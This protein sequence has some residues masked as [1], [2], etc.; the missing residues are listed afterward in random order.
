MGYRIT[1]LG[2]LPIEEDVNL[3]I[4]IVKLGFNTELAKLI[5]DNFEVLARRI[6]PHQSAIVD[7]LNDDWPNQ[8][9]SVFFGADW[10]T[11]KQYCPLMLITNAHPKDVDDDSLRLVVPLEEVH[12][13][14]GTY[15]RFF[16]E[17]SEFAENRNT[18]F[19]DKFEDQTNIVGTINEIIDIKPNVFG[20]GINI[21]KIIEKL[22]Q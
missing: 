4:F 3:Y 9:L 11:I 15:D 22:T 21:N 1:T 17:L 12:K 8:V 16:A 19:L 18:E 10:K 6:G 20:F 13:V 14:H 5:D 2:H 7:G